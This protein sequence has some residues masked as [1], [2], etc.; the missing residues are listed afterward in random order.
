L[1][2]EKMSSNAGAKSS[3]QLGSSWFGRWQKEILPG[4]K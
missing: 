4:D 1:N 3:L 2:L